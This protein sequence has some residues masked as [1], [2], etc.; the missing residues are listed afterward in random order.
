MHQVIG[1]VGF[2]M[3]AANAVA[4]DAGTRMSREDLLAFLPG[5]KVSHVSPSTGSQRAWTNEPDGHF[6]ASSDTKGYMGNA[7]GTQHATARGTWS[8][9]DQGKY[10]VE[11]DWPKVNA[12]KWCSSILKTADGGYYL[13]VVAPKS[14]IEFIK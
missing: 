7:L 12:E 8:V 14:K 6:V 10:C 1:V 4:Q 9:N 11:I 2:V 3:L 13:G 5:T